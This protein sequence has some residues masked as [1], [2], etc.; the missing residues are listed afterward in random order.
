MGALNDTTMSSPTD[1]VDGE[2]LIVGGS[3][4]ALSAAL[5][6]RPI[7]I[8]LSF[9]CIGTS[10]GAVRIFRKPLICEKCVCQP[11]ARTIDGG[12]RCAQSP[13]SPERLQEAAS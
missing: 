2:T 10:F 12:A 7:K 5:A 13:R 8:K 1:E 4:H 9:G 3:S 11:S 6:A